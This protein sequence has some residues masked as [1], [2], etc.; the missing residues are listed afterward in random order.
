MPWFKVD[1][2]L[3]VNMKVLA[4]G[5]TAMGLWVRAGSW[6]AAQL[7]NG[8]VP[9]GMVPVLGGSRRD[10]EA[11]HAAGLWHAAEGGWQFHDWDEYQPTR[12]QVLA[13]RAAAADRMRKVRE[14]KKRSGEQQAN[15]RANNERTSAERSDEVRD[16]FAFPVPSRPDPMTDRTTTTSSP[17]EVDAR[18]EQDE[19]LEAQAAKYRIKDFGR[20]R[21]AIMQHLH[22]ADDP[23]DAELLDILAELD[24]VA[25]GHVKSWYAYIEGSKSSDGIREAW[26]RVLASRP[27]AVIS[28]EVA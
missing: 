23:T 22:P 20:L 14:T 26:A 19:T 24:K 1:D 25:T 6:C 15:V 27:P 13:E 7:T 28:L 18:D 12:E 16:V 2:Q 9:D 3:A 10:A 4:A 21:V 8:F 17:T 5:N 11:L